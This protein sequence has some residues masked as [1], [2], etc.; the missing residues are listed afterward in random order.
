MSLIVDGF[1][2]ENHDISNNELGLLAEFASG[3]LTNKQIETVGG[4]NRMKCRV[5]MAV[6]YTHTHV[7]KLKVS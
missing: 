5:L 1:L 6:G 4:I 3:Y 2:A 7:S